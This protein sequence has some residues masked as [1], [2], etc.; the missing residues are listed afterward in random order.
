M[1]LRKAPSK[2][3]FSW[4]YFQREDILRECLCF[5][6]KW[7][8][9]PAD[10]APLVTQ[11]DVSS[12]QS[13]LCNDFPPL[14]SMLYKIAK[15]RINQK[16]SSTWFPRENLKTCNLP[17]GQEGVVYW[18]SSFRNRK[19]GYNI[20][21]CLQSFFRAPGPHSTSDIDSIVQSNLSN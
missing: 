17:R 7:L 16:Q 10:G 1:A 19:K 3:D 8:V 15:R 11:L 2:Y 9:S 4:G 21:T 14:T 6:A 5:R 18:G 12:K 13:D 20:L